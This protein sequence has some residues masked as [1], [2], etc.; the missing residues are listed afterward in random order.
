MAAELA[1][2]KVSNDAME[3]T[4]EL[5]SRIKDD[6]Y[7]FFKKLQDPDQL[8]K[9]RFEILEAIRDGEWL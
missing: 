8:W 1:E 5:R 2:L 6:G 4:K 7:L 9:L 3:D